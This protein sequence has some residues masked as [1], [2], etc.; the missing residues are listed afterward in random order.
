VVVEMKIKEGEWRIFRTSD[1]RSIRERG[2]IPTMT[3]SPRAPQYSSLPRSSLVPE[4]APPIE[5]LE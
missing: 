3:Y 1:E 2:T 4:D 5:I